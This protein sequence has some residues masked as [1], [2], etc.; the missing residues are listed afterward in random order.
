[1]KKVRKWKQEGGKDGGRK[2]HGSP[3][4]WLADQ[5][6]LVKKSLTLLYLPPSSFLTLMLS[7]G[8]FPLGP[9]HGFPVLYP[10]MRNSLWHSSQNEK[11]SPSVSNAVSMYKE[12]VR[13]RE[14]IE[15]HFPEDQEPQIHIFPMSFASLWD[16]IFFPSSFHFFL[17]PSFTSTRFLLSRSLSTSNHVLSVS[18][19]PG[20]MAECSTFD[21]SCS[22]LLLP[23]AQGKAR[24][25][26]C[27]S[28]SRMIQ[29]KRKWLTVVYP[30]SKT[31][32][33][34]S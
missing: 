5:C 8:G 11:S 25:E 19:A 32:L 16:T 33:H 26:A 18:S 2:R 34:I 17:P 24:L 30:L 22:G 13:C 15:T 1:M 27:L 4:T 21:G 31:K 3:R 6:L 7:G 20:V 9:S 12:Q 23:N 10:G 29:L 28:S 14:V